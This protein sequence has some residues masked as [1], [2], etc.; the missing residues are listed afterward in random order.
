MT[1]REKA[2]KALDVEEDDRGFERALNIVLGCLI[3]LSTA[4]VILGTVEDLQAEYSEWFLVIE[5][6]SLAVFSVEYLLR[7]WS[8]TVDPRYAGGITGRWRFATSPMA[9]IDLVAILPSLIPGGTLDLRFMRIFRL[10]RLMR[11]LKL[12]RYSE[13]L[14]L[15][16]RVLASRK[17]QLVA[18]AAA[19]CALLL[20]SSCAIYFVEHDAQPKT[21]SSIPASM[22]WGV[23]TLTT[24]GYGDVYPI[25]IL[26]KV[27]AGLIAALGIGL[28][29]LPAGIVAGGFTELLHERHEKKNCPHCGKVLD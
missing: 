16:V 11:A 14:Q 10:I 15:L 13:S 25:T 27:L 5:A 24:V 4:G 23:V 9:M 22:W 26:G 28:F 18:T 6:V 7:L 12:V 2:W 1:L 8:C 17:Q 19:G 29:A 3:V 21:F 20:V